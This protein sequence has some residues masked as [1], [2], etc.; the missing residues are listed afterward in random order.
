MEKLVQID[1]ARR[2]EAYLASKITQMADAICQSLVAQY[3]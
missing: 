2:I 3:T 1:N